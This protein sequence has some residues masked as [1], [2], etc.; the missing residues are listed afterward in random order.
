MTKTR[1]PGKYDRIERG[2]RN[3]LGGRVPRRKTCCT[4]GNR[5][6]ILIRPRTTGDLIMAID[7]NDALLLKMRRRVAGQRTKFP[8]AEYSFSVCFSQ[9]C[10]GST[11]NPVP[12]S[13]SRTPQCQG[14]ILVDSF[15]DS[16]R[17]EW[18][19]RLHRFQCRTI[20]F[21]RKYNRTLLRMKSKYVQSWM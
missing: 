11:G 6:R 20:L 1:P 12:V 13:I 19:E 17:L 8:A 15:R 3:K 5:F 7:K 21:S 4:R 18:T 2:T 9:S 14:F 10:G 16:L